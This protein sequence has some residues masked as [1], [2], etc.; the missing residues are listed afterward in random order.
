MF[1][2]VAGELR[3]NVPN[4]LAHVLGADRQETRRAMEVGLPSLIGGLRDKTLEPDG[5]DSLAELLTTDAGV[6]VGDVS[7]YIG[8]GDARRGAGILDQVF[9][10]RGEAALTSLGKA[11]GLSTRL[12]AQVMSVLAPVATGWLG[13]KARADDLD[14]EGVTR[15]LADETASLE[16]RGFGKVLTLLGGAGA[17]AT[18]AVAASSAPTQVQPAVVDPI[19]PVDMGAPVVEAPPTVQLDTGPSRVEVDTSTA[20]VPVSDFEIEGSGRSGLGRLWWV[21][22]ALVGIVLIALLVSRCGDDGNGTEPADEST[23]TET[24]TVNTE[25][26]PPTDPQPAPDEAPLVQQDLDR[27][28]AP[29]PN[30]MGVVNGDQA[31][32]TGTVPDE[33]TRDFVASVAAQVAGIQGVDNQVQVAGNSGNLVT[34]VLQGRGDLSTLNTLL[35]E[36]NLGDALSGNGPFTVFA[37]TNEAFALINEQLNTLRGDPQQLRDVLL[38][39]V[40]PGNFPAADLATQQILPTS[41]G[42]QISVSFDG[43]T[44]RLNDLV[45]VTETDITAD[46]G[47]IHV[48]TGVLTPPSGGAS[49]GLELSAALSLD[50]ITFEP[51]SS[52]LT[53]EGQAQL[54][55]VV[56]FLLENPQSVEIV[57]HTD[58]DGDEGFNQTLSQD[59]ANSVRQYLI[60]NGIGGD[61]LTATGKGEA[62]P[63]APNDTEENK[64]KNRRIEFNT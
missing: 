12:L 15:L 24:P 52:N 1:E 44:I 25:G 3:G 58:A 59:R 20:V 16:D 56:A 60:D 8:S 35:G 40:V 55:I 2:S 6:P 5:A 48:I 54:D 19:E 7:E 36:A 26:V 64:A 37:P 49:G 30:V 13:E 42:E 38:Y 10:E 18:A 29:F 14:A 31:V 62:E 33:G 63:V 43:T 11:S 21:L 28:L 22:A 61:S 41:Q 27:A 53:A 45:M 34:T 23:A 9:G 47:V 51:G 32:L 17:T 50:P 57:G 46:N 4:E 39:H